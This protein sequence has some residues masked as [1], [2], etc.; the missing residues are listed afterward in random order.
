VAQLAGSL[1]DWGVAD[2][3]HAPELALAAL[4]RAIASTL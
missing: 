1:I 4:L 2:M 3:G